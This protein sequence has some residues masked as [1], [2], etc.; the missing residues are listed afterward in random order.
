MVDLD[1]KAQFLRFSCF[2]FAYHHH[3]QDRKQ[4]HFY[5]AFLITFREDAIHYDRIRLH[6][7]M[8]SYFHPLFQNQPS[9]HCLMMKFHLHVKKGHLQIDVD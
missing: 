9:L 7:Q 5:L 4:T 6:P 3:S 8:M 1:L 2:F